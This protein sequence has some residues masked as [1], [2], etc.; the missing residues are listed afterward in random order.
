MKMVIA[1]YKFK[2][3]LKKDIGSKLNSNMFQETS[4]FGTEVT[5]NGIF[6]CTNKSRNWYAMI[7]VRD[8]VIMGVN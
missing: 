2:K 4:I 7:I 6:H 3:D 8:S 5:R 1:K